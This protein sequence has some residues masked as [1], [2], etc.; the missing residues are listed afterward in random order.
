MGRKFTT[1]DILMF[2]V[3]LI[4][5]LNLSVIKI[6]LKEIPPMPFNGIRLLLSSFLL[7]LALIIIEKDLRIRKDHIPKIIFLSIIGHT[8]YQLLFIKGIDLT[9]ASN[10]SIILGT[11]PI[12]IS[13]LSTYFKHERIKPIGW[14]GILFGFI[15]LYIVIRGKGGE[16]N[17]SSQTLKGDLLLFLAVILWSYYSV[18]SKLLLKVYSPLKFTGITMSLGSVLFFIFSIKEIGNLPFSSISLPAWLWL[19]YSGAFA[20]SLSLVIW[21]ISVKKVGNSQTAIYS[22]LQ[23]VFAVIFAHFILSENITFNLIIGAVIIIIGIYLARIG[24]EKKLK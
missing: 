6:S 2:I 24:K 15:G 7:I 18:S 11:S 12:I 9:T 3:I 1:I 20:L 23:P 10:T 22:N 19:F 14:L 8:I 5:G 16:V 13:L 17:I 4:W 21:F